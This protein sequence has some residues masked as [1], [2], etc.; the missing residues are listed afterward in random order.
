MHVFPLL[1]NSVKLR[2]NFSNLMN[3]NNSRSTSPAEST[4]SSVVSEPVTEASYEELKNDALAAKEGIKKHY[5][6]KTANDN[7]ELRELQ[8]NPR[9]QQELREAKSALDFLEKVRIKA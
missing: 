4:V 8:C 6:G 1:T 3:N 9:Y 5:E 7:K 2:Y